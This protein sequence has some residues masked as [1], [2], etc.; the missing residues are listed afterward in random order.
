MGLVTRRNFVGG[1]AAGLAL[2]ALIRGARAGEPLKVGFVYLGPIGDYGWTWAHEKGRKAMVDALKGQVVAD[3]VEN[4]KE[5]AS[6]APVIKDLAQQGHKLIFATTFGY[7]DQT[8][9]AAKQFPDAKFE[10]CTGYKHADNLGTYNTRF[11]QGRAVEG[12]MAG[13]M[14]KTG[15][16]GYLGSYKVPEVVQ[17]VNAFTLAA[18]AVNPK[19]TTKLI[20]IDSWFDPAKEAA[21]VQTLAN[22]GCDVIAQ[23]TD[24]PAGLQ[25]CEQRKVWCFGNAADMSRFAP[26][27][28][29][30]AIEDIWGPY[31]TSRA[32]AVLD[33]TWKSDDAWWGM[34]EG[35]LVMAPYNKA[36][37]DEVRAA[38]DK[39]IAGWKD[40][41]YDV[42]TGEIKD[43]TG[44]VKV[45]KGQRMEDKDL[46]VIDW[47][48]EG[49]QS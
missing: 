14:S 46:A 26:K 42:F 15:V 23:H 29:L 38:A 6:A 49:V 1:A 37:A 33:G 5:D 7:M 48:V 39:M 12:A 34:K 4:V 9:E 30:T 17:G 47:Y 21:A 25:V 13:L 16:V 31:Y 22:L 44:A 28:Q 43:Q 24:S 20:M 19:V 18:Q 8:V 40:D 45:A 41:S 2:P 27:T 3:Y 11:Y 35:A 36:I 10:H 32:K